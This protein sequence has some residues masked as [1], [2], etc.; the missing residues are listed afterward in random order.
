MLIPKAP[1]LLAFCLLLSTAAFIGCRKTSA[2]PA[3]SPTTNSAV[4]Q[5]QLHHPEGGTVS[6]ETRYFKGS[7]GTS[8]DLEMKLVR[9]GDQLSGSYFYRKVGSKIDLRGSVDK[10]GNL[11]LDEFDSNGKQTGVF[12]G[13]WTLDK[14]GAVALA[15]NWSKPPGDKGAD[16]KTAFS[17]HELPIKFATD[18]D[19]ANKQIK[20]QNKQLKFEID[21]QY[22]QFTV[23]AADDAQVRERFEK[24]NQSVKNL[25]LKKVADFKKDMASAENEGDMET[26]SAASYLDI[27]YTIEMAQDDFVSLDFLVGSYY[28]GAAHPNSYSETLNYDLRNGKPLKLADLFKPGAKFLPA[29]SSYAINDLKKQSRGEDK[30]L[31]DTSIESGAAP[32]AKNFESW[33]ITKKGLGIN[34]DPYQVGPYAAGPQY[35]VIPYSVLKEIIAPDGPLVQFVK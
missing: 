13:I 8:L 28:Q 3:A 5:D 30:M 20:E 1:L 24:L 29:I 4:S 9:S 10:E 25:I 12:K 33:T 23:T 22:P 7:I 31:D 16:K 34:F 35:V 2:P 27:S 6:R 15:G 19:V 14:D 18:V 21:A 32:S 26:E 17:I 11:T